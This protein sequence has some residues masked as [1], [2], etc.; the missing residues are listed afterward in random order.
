[1]TNFK[2]K[3]KMTVILKGQTKPVTVIEDKNKSFYYVTVDKNTNLTVKNPI[4]ADDVE[5]QVWLDRDGKVI[6]IGDYVVYLKQ[7]WNS[8]A[9][10]TI[11]KVEALNEVKITIKY[12]AYRYTGE[13][14]DTMT[15]LPNN[16]YIVTNEKIEADFKSASKN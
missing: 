12:I 13:V 1:M 14:I 16:T 5:K 11:G 9:T 15:V 4:N 6:E 2:L 3:N 8:G 7:G 10:L